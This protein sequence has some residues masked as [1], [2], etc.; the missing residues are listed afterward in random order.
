MGEVRA[1][2]DMIGRGLTYRAA[3]AALGRPEAAVKR[4]GARRKIRAAWRHP[5]GVALA[6][7]RECHAKG[8]TDELIARV[9][10]RT[11]ATVSKHRKKLGLP[12][13][14]AANRS[15][16][17]R[18][19]ACNKYCPVR[20]GPGWRELTGWVSRKPRGHVNTVEVYC[21]D[22]FRQ[23]GWGDELLTREG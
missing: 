4:Q 14:P 10:G 3:A 5:E 13:N 15:R 2:A 17:P 11:R 8:W 9:I 23:Y 6:L 12:I 18:C 16:R 20:P 21:P 7:V 1:L 19:W 22:C